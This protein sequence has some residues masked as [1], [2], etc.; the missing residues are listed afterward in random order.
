M[1]GIVPSLNTPFG[2]Q[3]AID[4]GSLRKLVE[5]TVQAGCGGMLGLAVAGEYQTLS[6]GEK[7]AFIETVT[8]ANAQRIPFIVSVTS[9]DQEASIALTKAASSAGAAGICVQ[10]PA[11]HNRQ[12]SLH[13]LQELACHAPDIV[14]VQ[15][16]DWTGGG[17]SLDDIGYLFENVKKFCWLKI[18][19]QQAGPKYSAVKE[20]TNGALNVCGG[21]AVTQLMDAMARELDA[22]HSHGNGAGLCRDI[23]EIPKRRSFLRPT[24][25]RARATDPEFL[26]PAYRHQHSVLQATQTGRGGYLRRQTVVAKMPN[27]TPCKRPKQ[28]SRLPLLWS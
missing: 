18:E 20:L 24:I 4:H 17:L 19:T 6:H 16:L 13:S 26:E 9:P 5:H 11:G 7:I 2:A 15:D 21:W 12:K 22:F 3:G 14:M 8:E 1:K 10:L 23:Q 25:V 28:V 27:L